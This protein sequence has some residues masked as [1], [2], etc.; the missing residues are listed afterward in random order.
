[1]SETEFTRE[2]RLETALFFAQSPLAAGADGIDPF[3]RAIDAHAGEL[4]P[5]HVFVGKSLLPYSHGAVARRI[6]QQEG[7][8]KVH[9]D[10]LRT[11]G[12]DVG[13]EMSFVRD[14]PSSFWMRIGAPLAHF[15]DAASGEARCRELVALVRALAGAGG[16][17]FGYSDEGDELRLG[18]DPHATDPF[19][20]SEV[21][22]AHWIDLFGFEMVDRIGR[23]R[24]LSTPAYRVEAL[25]DG[26][27]L[28]LTCPTP[29]DL[30]S[31]DARRAQARVL[32]HLRPAVSYDE[33]LARLRARSATLAPVAHRWDRD[34]ADL[35]ERTLTMVPIGER[36]AATERLNAYR[37]PVVT[38]WRPADALLPPDVDDPEKTIASYG[39]LWAEQFAALLHRDVRAAFGAGPDALPLVDQHFWQTDVPS[40][41][42]RLDIERRLVP[43]AGAYLG[44]ILVTHLGGRWVPRRDLDESQ[45]VVGSK[46]WL[47]FLR[48]R[49][50]L[51]DR[52]SIL[53]HSLTQFYR[54]AARGG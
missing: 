12:L 33:A 7:D 46:A 8:S 51:H 3:L 35:L 30:G 15:T 4:R 34:I 44:E 5:D 20:P 48:A 45:V 39:D 52:Q 9:V 41:F 54:V 43:A 1:M 23:E 29:A 28:V 19:A 16:P 13:F 11:K 47:P 49:H 24:V 37:P 14:E 17:A 10:V 42:P 18:S 22:E 40:A 2:H 26:S 31:E 6:A 53:D 38:E 21:Y 25:P 36:A 32:A 27:V 50:W